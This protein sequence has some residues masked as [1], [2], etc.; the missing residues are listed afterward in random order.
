MHDILDHLGDCYDKAGD[1]LPAQI[2]VV[3]K[4]TLTGDPD[5]GTIIDTDELADET[6]RPLEPGFDLCLRDAFVSLQVPPLSEGG[7]VK[8]T[9][10]FVFSR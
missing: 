8:V 7:E 2:K 6:G 9:Y 10:P 4:M 3:G 5:V 1:K